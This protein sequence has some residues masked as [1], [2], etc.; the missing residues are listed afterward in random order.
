GVRRGFGLVKER[1]K[2][3]ENDIEEIEKRKQIIPEL[4]GKEEKTSK[5]IFDTLKKLG[6]KPYFLSNTYNVV[7][8]VDVGKEKTLAIR[9]DI[10]ALPFE[11]KV[12]H[13]CGHDFHT[14]TLL[15]LAYIFSKENF[16][17]LLK[18]NL[19]FIFQSSEEVKKFSGAEAIVKA[20]ILEKENVEAIFCFHVYPEL[21]VGKIGVRSGPMMAGSDVFEFTI[22]GQRLFYAF[23][24]PGCSLFQSHGLKLVN[25][26]FCLDPCRLP[27]F[28]GMDCL[29]HVQHHRHMFGRYR[30]GYIA[31]KM[32]GAP[33]PL[34]MWKIRCGSFHQPHTGIRDD[35]PYTL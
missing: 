20:G 22:K 2:Q 15:G 24:N 31:V 35:Q 13:A 27:V 30:V 28:T 6:Y 10:D 16:R 29:E 17:K 19:L 11:D 1:I 26:R 4:S 14:A 18:T 33:L 23:S 12:I 21:P 7:C 8:K 34:G 3:Q 9:A 32:H 5:L 25:D